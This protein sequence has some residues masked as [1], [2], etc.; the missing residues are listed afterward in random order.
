MDLIDLPA[1]L[2]RW[3]HILCVVVVVGGAVFMRVVLMPAADEAL[4]P[5][6]HEQL[7]AR[8]IRRWKKIVHAGVALLMVSGGYNF[9]MA[10][11]DQVPPKPYHAIFLAKLL[12]A[13]AVFFFAVALTSSSPGF[14]R[15]R[16]NSRK[17]LGVQ[18]TLAV[19]I[20]MLSGVLKSLHQAALAAPGG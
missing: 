11:H 6:L 12:M 5:E 20:I 17:W 1:I 13:L 2:S 8:V 3:V 15:L 7:R 18:I 4:S 14:A 19:L 10:I 9:Y 16:E